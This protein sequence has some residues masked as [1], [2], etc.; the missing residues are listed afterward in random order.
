[1]NRWW[2][3]DVDRSI[4]L[5]TKA[6]KAGCL[7]AIPNILREN[8]TWNKRFRAVQKMRATSETYRQRIAFTV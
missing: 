7:E 6:Q 5:R 3:K 1:M 8:L 4:R 2:K